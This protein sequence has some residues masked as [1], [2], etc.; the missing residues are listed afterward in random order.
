[1]VATA[2][3]PTH[4]VVGVELYEALHLVRD[5]VPGVHRVHRARLHAGIAVD[6]LGRI[7]VEVLD[8]VVVRLV[9]RR[10]DA[11]DGTHVDARVVLLTDARLGDDVR[12]WRVLPRFSGSCG[13]TAFPWPLH[14]GRPSR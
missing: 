3:L 6:A 14:A 5:L 12:H 9:G 4:E 8:G 2:A 7:D 13:R 10:V 1:M 11:V